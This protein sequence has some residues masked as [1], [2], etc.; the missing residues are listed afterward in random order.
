M[1]RRGIAA[2]VD[3]LHELQARV[4]RRASPRPPPRLRRHRARGQPRL[5][6]AAAGGAVRRAR[7]AQDQEDQDRLHHRRRR[8]DLAA[9]ADR[10]PVPRAPAAPPRRHPAAHGRRRAASRW[11][12]TTAASTPRST[13][14]SRRPAGCPRPT[15][16]CRTSRSAP[17][18][19]A[20][21][22]RRS[23]S[24]TGYESLM[25]ADYSQIEMRI[26]AHL[27]GDE[28]LIEAF[29]SGEDLHTFVASRA[30]DIPIE[31]VDP[32]AAPPDQGD[33]LR[34]GLRA[35]ARTGWPSS[36]R[37][38]AGRGARADGRL[39]RALRRHPRLPRRRR[40]RG[41]A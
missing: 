10:A 20:G 18:R 39:L 27:S 38:T 37:I 30:F 7:P 15:R 4:R 32:R 14:R 33:D 31:Q 25:T 40:R 21:S 35:V 2:D 8:A 41:P 24:A 1:E 16:T 19:A 36:S 12:T 26:M 22:G 9:R 23:S 34:P 29:T 17:P 6:Q 5:A 11:S 3:Y 13:R 28:G